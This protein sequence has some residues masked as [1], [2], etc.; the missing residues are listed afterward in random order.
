[1]I[2]LSTISL[3][4]ACILFI[5]PTH[6]HALSAFNRC[7]HPLLK[8]DCKKICLF[9]DAL[10]L[11]SHNR[12][13]LPDPDC[14]RTLDKHC[15]MPFC[16]SYSSIMHLSKKYFLGTFPIGYAGVSLPALTNSSRSC[17]ISS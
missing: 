4:H 5:L 17:L 3:A 6:S 11:S 13:S 10:S 2:S 9:P 14:N 12:I 16:T 15:N 8:T 1:M 7:Y